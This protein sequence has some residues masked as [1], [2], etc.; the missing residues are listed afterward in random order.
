MGSLLETVY[1]VLVQP[2]AAM[3][4]IAAWKLTGQAVVVFFLSI[5][6]SSLM[7]A[8]VLKNAGLGNY[9]PLVMAFYFG[10]SLLSWLISAAVLSLV[11]EFFGGQ[12]TARGLFA[13][14]GFARLPE[15]FA[16]P[17][18]ALAAMAPAGAKPFLLIMGGV[19]L[20]GWSLLL[21]VTAIRGA[22]GLSGPRAILTLLTPVLV[23][24]GIGFGLAMLLGATILQNFWR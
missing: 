11:A 22:H 16:A 10:G 3:R 23:V 9:I 12:G 2:R 15:L 13:A 20:S 6:A 17:L 4:S 5:T 14:L 19:L 8:P 7:L 18:S 1:D 24:I 21:I